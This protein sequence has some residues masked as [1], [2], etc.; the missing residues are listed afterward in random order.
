MVL[1]EPMIQHLCLRIFSVFLVYHSLAPILKGLV[2]VSTWS[3]PLPR[4]WRPSTFPGG[5]GLLPLTAIFLAASAN[6]SVLVIG[7]YVW[8]VCP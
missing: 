7:V 8:C 4:T 3:C 1:A 6:Y 5:H 2:G